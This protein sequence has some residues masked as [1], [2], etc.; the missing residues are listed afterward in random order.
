VVSGHR[1]HKL[2]LRLKIAMLKRLIEVEPQVRQVDTW[3]A[4]SNSHMIA[5]NDAIGCA[6]VGRAVE[7]QR[8]LALAGQPAP[9]QAGQ[10]QS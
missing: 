2:G 5:V 1:G 4:E 9:S 3:N 6:V 8:R 7:M 10:A